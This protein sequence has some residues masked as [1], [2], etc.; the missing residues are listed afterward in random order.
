[1]SPYRCGSGRY[2]FVSQYTSSQ[3]VW[4]EVVV[5]P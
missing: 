4:E 2:V 5:D 1:M 3:G